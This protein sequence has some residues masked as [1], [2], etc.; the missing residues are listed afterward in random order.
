MYNVNKDTTDTSET[1]KCLK[2]IKV[3]LKFTRKKQY[4]LAVCH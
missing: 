2:I 4:N 3:I 1:Y